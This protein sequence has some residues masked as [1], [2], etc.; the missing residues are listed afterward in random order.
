[1]AAAEAKLL[2]VPGLRAHMGDWVY[3][4]TFLRIKDIAERISL[5]T[6]IHT[7]SVLRELIQREIESYHSDAIRDYLIR[8]KERF[9]NALVIG[10]YGGS[11]KWAELS[12]TQTRLKGFGEI[13]GYIEGA[14]GILVLDGS[15]KL[16]AIDGQHR[17]VG[18]K[19]AVE[20]KPELGEEEVTAIFVAHSTDRR[21][22]ERT[23]RLFTTL[24]RYAKP[25]NKM[26]I[27]A[28]DEDDVVATV[29]RQ[30]VDTHPL[31]VKWTSIKKGKAISHRDR[32]NFTTII[33]IYDALDVFL[34]DEPKG[35]R[36]F[37]RSRP[38]DTV[39]RAFYEKAKNLWDEI[40]ECFPPLSELAGSNPEDEVA[41][42]YRDRNGGHL[43]FRPVGL[44][45]L[46]Q[47]VRWFMD[48]GHSL[49]SILRNAS[50]VPM[51]LNEEPWVGLLWDPINRR[52]IVPSENQNAAKRIMFYGLGGKLSRFDSSQRQLR[53]ELAGL[54]GKGEADVVL[55]R[56][57]RL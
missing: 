24:N 4:T 8:Q 29:T 53:R 25:V 17:V 40:M 34:A 39:I 57:G 50:E 47:V 22:M 11:P 45:T 56:W 7:S 26:Q 48:E 52:M 43:L 13:P 51:M 55:H 19:K 2:Q 33:T 10:V 30:I 31:F 12:I 35:W 28:L 42:R 44:S 23:R 18:M 16:F 9:F 36:N 41:A 6:E 54:L 5:A 46:V 20:S 3:Y 37:K 1:M 14:L 38:P 15:E 21:G 32:R 49:R 27:I